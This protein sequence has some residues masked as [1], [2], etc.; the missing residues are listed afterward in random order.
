MRARSHRPQSGF[1]LIELLVV[2]AIIAI[3]VALLLPAVQQAREAARRSQC[4]NN[5]KQ[6]GVALHNYHDTHGVLPPASTPSS[7]FSTDRATWSW[8]VM[9]LPNID[10][11]PLYDQ[12]QP[13][14][15]DSLLEALSDPTRVRLMQTIIDGY[16]CPSDPGPALNNLRPLDLTGANVEVGRANYVGNMGVDQSSPTEGLFYYNSNVRFRDVTDGLSNTF[17][18]GERAHG[19]IKSTAPYGS[20]MWPGSTLFPCGP[21]GLPTD[22]T[23]GQ[24]G[25]VSYDLQTGI[26]ADGSG[27]YLAFWGFSSMH[28]GGVHFL[29]ADGAVHFV[30]ESVESRIGNATDSTTWGT[31]QKLGGRN[32]GELPGDF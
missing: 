18:M 24:Y 11:A 20:A 16:L 3:L 8:A 7:R 6:I 5:L 30:N 32:D 19:T 12:L 14:S 27:I 4:K 25:N 22:C 23:I 26:A 13:N 10:Q 31:Y 2:I 15:P 9:I 21:G 17:A 1:T 28:A 29:L